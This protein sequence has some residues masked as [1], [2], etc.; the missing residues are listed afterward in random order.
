[1]SNLVTETIYTSLKPLTENLA[2]NLA[3]RTVAYYDAE[4]SAKR[5]LA[6]GVG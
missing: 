2:I 3:S 1:M 4:S 6:R 5:Q